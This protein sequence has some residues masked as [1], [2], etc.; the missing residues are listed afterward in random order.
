LLHKT[1]LVRYPRPQFIVSDNWG[2]FKR[3]FKQMCDNYVIEAKPTSSYNPL[4]H[5]IIERVHKVVNYMLRSFGLETNNE[6]LEEPEDNSFD[7]FL[8]PTAWTIR[9][10]YHTALQATPC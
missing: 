9:S 1:W 6:N 10:T 7:Y 2:E 5:S 8:Q 4:A 3:E